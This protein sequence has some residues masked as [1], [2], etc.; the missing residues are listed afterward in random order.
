MISV[1][2]GLLDEEGR[3]NISVD[4]RLYTEYIYLYYY[5]YYY[6]TNNVA[7]TSRL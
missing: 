2:I 3:V 6:T 4:T 7:P 5:Y 1:C